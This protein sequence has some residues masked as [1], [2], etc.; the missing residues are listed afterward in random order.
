MKK[1]SKEHQWVAVEGEIARMGITRFAAEQLGDI[2]FLELPQVGDQAVAGEPLA[3]VESVK[4]TSDI[5][6]PVSGEVLA[7][8]KE[9][10]EMPEIMNKDPEGEAWVAE[11]RLENPAELDE[12][13]TEEEYLN[14][15]TGG[16]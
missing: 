13:M 10:S 3:M 11:L 15:L 4:S 6:A 14:F 2:V 9:L 7:V 16:N 5:Y 1:Y 8:K 12:L